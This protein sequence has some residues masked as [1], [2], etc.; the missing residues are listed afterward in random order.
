MRV[1]NTDTAALAGAAQAT[2]AAANSAAAR[3]RSAST[4]KSSD[5]TQLSSLSTHLKALSAAGRQAQVDNIGAVVAAGRYKTDSNAIS[6]KM[7]TDSMRSG[8]T[9]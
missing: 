4:Q 1:T 6:A 7:I 3:A 2:S 5:Y 9:A 8:A